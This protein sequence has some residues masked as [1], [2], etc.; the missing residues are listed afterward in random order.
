[1]EME[2]RVKLSRLADSM[3]VCMCMYVCMYVCTYVCVCVYVCMCEWEAYYTF[4][5]SAL[6][7]LKWNKSKYIK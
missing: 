3:Y 4:V 5:S 7:S 1:M 6:E 2:S